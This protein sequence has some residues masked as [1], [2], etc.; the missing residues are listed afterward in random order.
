MKA[1][2]PAA[3]KIDKLAAAPSIAI[4]S[5]ATLTSTAI[6]ESPSLLTTTAGSAHLDVLL[7][8]LPSLT[9]SGLAFNTWLTFRS[10]LL[11]EIIK[12]LHAGLSS[13]SRP[14]IEAHAKALALLYKQ[15]I[16]LQA[17]ALFPSSSKQGDGASKGRGSDCERVLPHSE[18]LQLA[19]ILVERG[20]GE[21]NTLMNRARDVKEGSRRAMLR[22]QPRLVGKR[23]YGEPGKDGSAGCCTAA[24][25]S[26]A[27]ATNTSS[28]GGASTSSRPKAPRSD[29]PLVLSLA[30]RLLSTRFLALEYLSALDAAAVLPLL[31]DVAM[32]LT[33]LASDSD[34]ASSGGGSTSGGAS[35]SAASLESHRA[36]VGA[37]AWR[38]LSLFR[39]SDKDVSAVRSRAG[40]LSWEG[41][42]NGSRG[43]RSDKDGEVHPLVFDWQPLHHNHWRLSSCE[44]W[45]ERIMRS[46][47]LLRS[48]W[49]R[50]GRAR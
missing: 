3:S 42:P 25:A 30:L 22:I 15:L 26:T 39:H 5:L 44:S 21:G 14:L 36:V 46:M 12:K 13:R 9:R 43:L 35:A 28:D 20:V 6:L 8:P 4:N 1:A 27:S 37:L 7:D 31:G 19:L 18:L 33:T 24:S 38:L 49:T 45:V 10:S 29:A 48:C 17:V 32:V 34:D 40:S 11:R 16:R 47:A 41:P 2:A 50:L 23:L